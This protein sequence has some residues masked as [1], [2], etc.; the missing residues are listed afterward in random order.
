V[1]VLTLD[2]WGHKLSQTGVA[3]VE[4][5]PYGRAIAVG[6]QRQ[7]LSV[8]S[9][10]DCRLMCSLRQ[11]CGG[12]RSALGGMN[13]MG[14]SSLGRRSTLD[15]DTASSFFTSVLGVPAGANAEG[16]SEDAPHRPLEAPVACLFWGVLGYQLL[17]AELGCQHLVELQFARSL[18]HHHR[19][20]HAGVMPDT[21]GGNHGEELHVMQAHDRLLVIAEELSA[22]SAS[23]FP[24]PVVISSEAN[25]H[26]PSSSQFQGSPAGSGMP[27]QQQGPDLTVSHIPVPLSYIGPNWSLLHTSISS[28][29][30]HIAVAA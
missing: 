23:S 3:Q 26:I 12:D 4:W 20:A 18:S 28:N 16:S 11:P 10:S 21:A 6:Y 13:L 14:M 27:N 9:P 24:I 15:S 30:L 7:G 25:H 8:W 1:R 5:S 19:V 22:V 17:I 29:G 2:P